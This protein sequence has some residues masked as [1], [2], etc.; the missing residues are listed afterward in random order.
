[1]TKLVMSY[2]CT[3]VVTALCA[4]K[5]QD[6]GVLYTIN[7][8]QATVGGACFIII[9]LAVTVTLSMLGLRDFRYAVEDTYGQEVINRRHQ[10]DLN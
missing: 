6:F 10:I 7:P 5:W 4:V 3:A 8:T 9:A 2:I 1:M